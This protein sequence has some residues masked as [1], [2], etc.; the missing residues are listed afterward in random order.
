MAKS[1]KSKFKIPN[2]PNAGLQS[3]DR[4]IWYSDLAYV[5]KEYKEKAIW[6]AQMI[7]YSKKNSS[8]LI[9]PMV[10]KGYRDNDRGMINEQIYRDIIDPPNPKNAGGTAEFMASDFK[11]Y[12]I[13]Q[14][15][16]NI[17]R[18]ALEKIPHNI[19]VKINDPVA[20]SQEQLDKE[21]IIMQRLVRGIINKYNEEL[22]LPS[23]EDGQDPYKWIEAFSKGA[24]GDTEGAAKVD[25]IGT[26][27]DQI[28][29]KI[30]N[31]DQL[32]MYMQY[33]YKNGLEIAFESAIQYYFINLNKW[34]LKQ[35]AFINDL[36]N[37]NLFSGMWYIDETTGRPVVKYLDPST[38]Y[39]SPFIEKN[40]DDIMYWGTEFFVSYAD[41]EKMC[42]AELSDEQKREILQVNKLWGSALNTNIGVQTAWNEALRTN[43]QM[44][45]GY[46]SVLTQE[47]QEFSEYYLDH[48]GV[49][50]SKYSKGWDEK[51]EIN[52]NRPCRTYNVWYSCYYIPLPNTSTNQVTIIG[53]EGWE[54]L[55]RYVFKIQKEIDMYRYGVDQRY[56]KSALV[57]YRDLTRMSY[58][59]IKERFMPKI[60]TLWHK[61]QNCLVQDVNAMGWDSDLLAGLL[62]AVDEANEKTKGGGEQLVKEMKSLKQSGVAWLK[63]RDK[64]G[65]MVVQDPS[66]LFVAIKSGHMETAERYMLM[67]LNL[68]SQMTQALAISPASAGQQPDPRVAASGIEIANEAT[69]N[70][71]WFL[72]KPV[73]ELAIM[74]GE[75][76]IQYV[77]R[78][79]KE[80]DVYNYRERWNEFVDIVGLANGATIEGIE[81]IEFENIGVTVKN[82][83]TSAQKQI[84]TQMLLQKT[85]AK[86][87]S[88]TDLGLIMDT[89]NWKLQMIELAMAEDKR[90]E[91][92]QQ[93]EEA[94]HRRQMEIQQMQL[95]V[96]QALQGIKTQGNIAEI[97]AQGQVDSQLAQ[98]TNQI[99]A[100]TQALLMQQR[101]EQKNQNAILQTEL[102]KDKEKNRTDLKAQEPITL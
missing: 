32:R 63:F 23:I 94:N 66:K 35:D 69:M 6:I 65:N 93:Q 83:N 101:G 61:I 76:V 51:S 67:I 22:G 20:K 72:E 47:A 46:F 42:G 71:R 77:N 52:E 31:D 78:I 15:L 4:T 18:A 24:N 96:A 53:T 16:D 92:L 54:W 100:Q 28:R 17:V 60:N 10:A 98:L 27:V 97:Q 95:Q 36:K 99:K 102:E 26:A 2:T 1:K 45:L 84:I 50:N 64:N 25:T 5:P 68:Y 89:D 8:L 44:K 38:V 40:G 81:D 30:K 39:T 43:S 7:F 11:N 62:N 33:V 48:Q 14:H 41:F 37:F 87:L 3:Q 70:A 88:M 75:R 85:A 57:I 79:C 12:P 90:N 29:N 82:E 80:K 91:L 55:S 73:I 58:S 49:I 9:D 34:H 86:E 13:D 74:Y 59:Q 21:K 56:A 19:S